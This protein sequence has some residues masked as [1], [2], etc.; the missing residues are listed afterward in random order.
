[1]RHTACI[2]HV[3]IFVC[4]VEQMV[5]IKHQFWFLLYVRTSW[6]T[7]YSDINKL[8]CLQHDVVL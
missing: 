5:F 7:Y 1:M 2:E 3:L 8:E 6:C 4:D